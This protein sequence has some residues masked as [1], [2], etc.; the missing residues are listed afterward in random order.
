MLLHEKKWPLGG[1]SIEKR[2]GTAFPPALSVRKARQT[3]LPGSHGSVSMVFAVIPPIMM[4]FY[5]LDGLSLHSCSEHSSEI[6][7][8]STHIFTG[9][10]GT[11]LD[12]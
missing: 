1:P 10:T 6:E 5:H 2:H 7:V 4:L 9:K 3:S 8:L 11:F 12:R